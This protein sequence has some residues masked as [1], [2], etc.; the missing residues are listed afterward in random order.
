MVANANWS[1]PVR[2]PSATVTVPGSKSSSARKSTA[3]TSESSPRPPR[4]PL[5]PAQPMD[6]SNSA[7]PPFLN[8]TYDMVEDPSTDP[9]V[10]WNP[11]GNG[12]IV[13][14]LNEFQQQLL[15]KFFKHNNFSSFVRQLNT[16]GFRKVDPDRWEF[17]NEGFLK[18][19]KQLL[20][21]IHRK[22][23]ASHQPPAVQQPQPQPQPSSKPACVE[24]G[25][26]GLEGEIERLKRDKNVLMS[27]LVRLRQQQQQT[28]SDLQ[29][30][31]QRLH[32]TEQR[33]QQMISF[34]AKAMQS[35]SFLAHLVQQ[36]ES[37][38]RLAASARKKRRLP[39][40]QDG[41]E[42]QS[43][44]SDVVDETPSP[45]E[46]QIVKYQ[47]NN[48]PMAMLMH[49]FNSP[50]HSPSASAGSKK[51]DM[52]VSFRDL[53]LN[54]AQDGKGLTL[55]EMH[56]AQ[57]MG[58]LL[59]SSP[60]RVDSGDM[61]IAPASPLSLMR[62]EALAEEQQQG[63]SGDGS[64]GGGEEQSK[65]EDGGLDSSGVPEFM[66]DIEWDQFL[67]DV[68]GEGGSDNI[69]F[70]EGSNANQWWDENGDKVSELAEQIGQLTSTT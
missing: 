43:D 69:D 10:S 51:L 7:P 26:F 48:D 41:S 57:M 39:K 5:P 62:F 16:Y 61:Q 58:D 14:N 33:Q 6:S 45:G 60:S 25:K 22:K 56:S 32:V 40:Q 68:A 59:L 18:G 42:Q 67:A 55:T 31:L 29:M 36:N 44:G 19:K 65:E 8:K 28:D 1:Q 20:K 49:F 47:P 50:E 66:M 53:D 27:E 30:I 46:G 34:L 70:V 63:E 52:E 37:K 54:P 23:S 13:W 24:V 15:P 3:A 9:I 11:S 35:P 12:F 4:P 2:S 64:G 21:G 17:G 38:K